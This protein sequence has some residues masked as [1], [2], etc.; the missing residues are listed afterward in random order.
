MLLLKLVVQRAHQLL[1]PLSP[2]ACSPAAAAAARA[3]AEAAA[4]LAAAVNV[5]LLLSA[6][7]VRCRQPGYSL[8]HVGTASCDLLAGLAAPDANS[9]ALHSEL[10]AVKQTTRENTYI[11]TP[12]RPIC[13]VA[14]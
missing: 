14:P 12:Q 6:A 2:G 9:H 4:P 1:P 10:Q 5:L 11:S 8:H 3:A 7:S 13:L